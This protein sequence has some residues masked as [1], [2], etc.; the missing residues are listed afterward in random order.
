MIEIS[1]AWQV[2]LVSYFPSWLES[3]SSHVD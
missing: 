3:F 2:D 1:Q